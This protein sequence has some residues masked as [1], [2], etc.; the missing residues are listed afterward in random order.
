MTAMK[1]NKRTRSRSGFS[2]IETMIAMLVLG[3]G[4]LTIASAQVYAVKSGQTGRHRT[5]A[6]EI[7]QT[8]MERLQS[9]SW[10]DA[11]LVATGWTPN[12]D[13]VTTV[14]STSAQTAMTFSRQWR[15]TD[16]IANQTRSIDVRVGWTDAHGVTKDFA[17]SSTRFNFEGL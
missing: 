10:N 17:L 4:L 9:L 13:V 1:I 2:M 6:V 16:V 14:E 7:A 5:R 8:Q 3:F 12:V 15:I 11:D